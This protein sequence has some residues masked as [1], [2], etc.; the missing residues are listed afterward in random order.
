MTSRLATESINVQPIQ[1]MK[2]LCAVVALF[3][4]ATPLVAQADTARARR[5]SVALVRELERALGDTARRPMSPQQA[6]V[7]PRLLP[8]ISAVGDLIGDLSPKGPT[9]EDG[10]RFGVR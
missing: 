3:G 8:D 6:P 1:Q 7:N 4:V 5:D 2:I 10:T 9:Q